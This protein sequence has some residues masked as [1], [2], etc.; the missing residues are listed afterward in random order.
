MR[1]RQSRVDRV[2]YD[3]HHDTLSRCILIND[4]VI[5]CLMFR[6]CESAG[7]RE[8]GDYIGTGSREIVV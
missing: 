3:A 2:G 1:V 5:W 4:D 7:R 8:S 6:V